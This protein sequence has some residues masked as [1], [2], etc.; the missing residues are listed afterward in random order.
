MKS[1]FPK[2]N[3]LKDLIYIQE[4]KPCSKRTVE[5]LFRS[6]VEPILEENTEAL[7]L[8]RLE[9]KS[10]KT[11]NSLLKRL[12]Y[13]KA[14]VYDF[15]DEKF[16]DSFENVLI[17]R[18]WDK[19]EFIYVLAQRFGAVMIFDFDECEIKNFANIYLL[20]NSK[21]LSE[22]FSVINSNSLIDLNDENEKYHP[23]RRDNETL[24]NSIRKIVS[25]LDDTN[26]EVLVSEMGEKTIDE[27]EEL[28]SKVK[29]LS[30]KSSLV[31]HEIRNQL[32]ICKLYSTIIQ[33]RM[34][35][36]E[37][38]DK[39]VKDSI[40]NAIECITKS[41]KI[42][43]NCLMDLKTLNNTELSNYDLKDM[44]ETAISLSEVYSEEKEITINSE[45]AEG[46][47]I[48]ADEN[49][50]LSII[51]NMIKNAV[52]SIEEKGEIDIIADSSKDVI[53]LKISNNGKEMEKE[54][55][56]HIFDEGFTTKKTGSGLGL[57]ICKKTLEEQFAQLQL[58]HSDE[59]T[60]E[61]EILF[62]K[63]KK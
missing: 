50:F 37:I 61:F 33:K 47:T 32:S 58:N 43:D 25:I 54:V 4:N 59:K 53:S 42:S 52:E 29:F 1:A 8:C 60:T 6:I 28:K 48:L 19:T 2:R 30:E 7:I 13:S 17:D 49:K 40:E 15:S 3:K 51:V 36:I 5:G 22:A 12:E 10:Q 20:H 23:D 55:Q 31:S 34:S 27:S 9:A 41:L 56:E 24:N 35:Q 11:F 39:E 21:L 38:K 26:Q 44:V 14:K 16:S 57:Y 18:I 46:I 62:P 45:I 63:I